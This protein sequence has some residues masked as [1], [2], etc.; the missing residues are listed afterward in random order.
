MDLGSCALPFN[1]SRIMTDLD[2][3]AEQHLRQLALQDHAKILLVLAQIGAQGVGGFQIDVRRSL[4]FRYGEANEK[5][6]LSSFDRAQTSSI[7]SITRFTPPFPISN[8][9][10]TMGCAKR[11][12][13]TAYRDCTMRRPA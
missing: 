2:Y 11:N 5:A 4:L 9:F 8:R 10:G 1:I 12:I 7:S 13:K 6:T 3:R